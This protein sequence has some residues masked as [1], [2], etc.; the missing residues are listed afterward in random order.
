MNKKI[1]VCQKVGVTLHSLSGDN[2]PRVKR[3][4]KDIERITID[5]K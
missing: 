3:K 5:K 4:H 1:C 2:G